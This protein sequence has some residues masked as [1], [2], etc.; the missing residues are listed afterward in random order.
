MR[1]T[2]WRA[3]L[4]AAAAALATLSVAAPGSAQYAPY[5]GQPQYA[6][7]P[8]INAAGQY[9]S[10]M[11][12][13]P[14]QAQPQY[15]A[16][17]AYQ[18]YQAPA[19]YAQQPVT[20]GAQPQ[21]YAP[22]VAPRM[23]MAY[24]PTPGPTPTP[25]A[26]NLPL[27][28]PAESVAPGAMQGGAYVAPQPVPAADN[29]GYGGYAPGGY[30][31]Y[32]AANGAGC[33]TGNCG[34]GSTNYSSAYSGSCG[35]TAYGACDTYSP[36][37][38]MNGCL[39]KHVGGGYWFGG[40]YGLLM[41]RDNSNKYPLAFTVNPEMPDGY[42]PTDINVVMTTRSVDVGF[43]PGVE[44]RLGRAF[45]GGGCGGCD[46]CGTSACGYGGGGCGGCGGGAM[47]GIEGVYWTLF[48]DDA[49]STYVSPASPSRTYT[50]MPM[51]GLEYDGGNGYNPVNVYW[52][53]GMPSVQANPYDVTTVRQRSSFE[54]QNVELNM[55]RLG[56]CGGGYGGSAYSAAYGAS[57]CGGGSCDSGCATGGCAT[58]G[59]T[60]GCAPC[61]P[62]GPR[63]S[64]TCVAGFRYMRFDEAFMF[65]VDYSGPVSGF[66]NYNSNV[67]N[68]LFGAQIGCNGMYRIGCK[69]GVHCN[70]LVGLYGNDIDVRQY[71]QS[72]TNQIR[73]IGDP[74][75][76][77]DVNASKTD[78][79]MLGEL[80]LGLSYQ[81]T[82]RCRVYGGWRAIGIAG[83]AL[84]TDQTPAAF[85]SEAQMAS[86]V[87]SNGSM[88]LHGLQ[89][90]VEWNY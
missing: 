46:P 45:G 75:N 83:L 38:G 69:W 56:V 12:T 42:P 80:R 10:Y 89:T 35:T 48:D 22:Y 73:Y 16:Q 6:A 68:N 77:F 84:A 27:T 59:C 52:D 36:A 17:G 66:L 85:L 30:E 60:T 31:S 87:N 32:P 40:V 24:Q 62:C 39:G 33:A 41:D 20:P 26:E 64:C 37:G 34:A 58:G 8:Q 79:S 7:Q 44:F 28:P 81:A 9:G 18:G 78:V 51:Y 47:W 61:V 23:A 76:N 14:T 19:N 82:C 88:I 3:R 21:A 90:G 54:A 67:Q 86:Y 49:T 63:Y 72:P 53:H 55:L 70:T 13:T 15:A 4:L 25:S 50:M 11:P 71:F 65:G 57:S 2:L 43:Q 1:I 74:A 5:A 29:Y